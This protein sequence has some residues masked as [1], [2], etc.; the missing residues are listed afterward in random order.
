MSSA[1]GH[2]VSSLDTGDQN[3][4]CHSLLSLSWPD[5]T[6]TILERTEIQK[7]QAKSKTMETNMRTMLVSNFHT[8]YNKGNL[9]R[10]K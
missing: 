6:V 10:D 3:E 4:E 5:C 2:E 1:H 8:R 7:Q 9:A